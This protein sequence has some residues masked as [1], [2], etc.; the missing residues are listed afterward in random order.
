MINY[1]DKIFSMLGWGHVQVPNRHWSNE[2][3]SPFCNAVAV[4]LIL[5]YL[6]WELSG[7]WIESDSMPTWVYTNKGCEVQ[8]SNRDI[9][10]VR[11]KNGQCRGGITIQESPR[12]HSSGMEKVNEHNVPA[13]QVFTF[14]YVVQLK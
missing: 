4:C 14:H 13:V 10:T 2:Q 6:E 12:S 1:I 5:T 7:N 3:R 11:R 9:H 8:V